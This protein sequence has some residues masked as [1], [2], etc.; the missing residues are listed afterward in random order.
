MGIVPASRR[1][2][3]PCLYNTHNTTTPTTSITP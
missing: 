3:V 2:G 1:Q